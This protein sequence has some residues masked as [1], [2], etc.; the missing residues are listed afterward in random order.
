[1]AYF[2]FEGKSIYYELHGEGRPLLLLNGIMMSCGSWAEFVEPLS[3][4]NQLILLDMLDQGRSAKMTEAY[5]HGIQIRL[6]DALLD[7]LGLE[8]VCVAGISYGS[9]VGLEYAIEHPERVERLMLFN[10]TA[11]TGAWLNDVG[12]AW[13]LAANDGESYYYTSIPVI[14]SPS[15][16]I[17]HNDW[18]ERRKELLVP[19]FNNP[20]FIQAMIRLTNSSS[21]YDVRD[22]LDRVACPVLIVSC[23]QDYLTPIEEQQYLARNIKDS[24]YLV[25]QNSGHA[26]MYE[27]PLLFTSLILGFANTVKDKFNIV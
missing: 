1:M 27:Q 15:F 21:N 8:K 17:E 14:Y 26:S 18:M 7:H 25:I 10:A 11:A 22:R 12:K 4:Q 24:H 9:E 19:I 5:D 6:V 23:Q 20:D 13:N 3:A 2:D 16:F